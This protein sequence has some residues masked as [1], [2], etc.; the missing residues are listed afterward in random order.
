V[1]P[2]LKAPRTRE[3]TLGY[4]HEVGKQSFTATLL[5][6][7]MDRFVDDIWYGNGISDG[8]AKILISM[9]RTGARTTTPLR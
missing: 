5:R 2:N 8:V 6:R 9:T 3:L 7:W 1:D 4:R